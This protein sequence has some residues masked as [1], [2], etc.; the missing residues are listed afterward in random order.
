MNKE[1]DVV[2]IGYNRMPKGCDDNEM[3]WA[4]EAENKWATK[5]PYGELLRFSW[6]QMCIFISHYILITLKKP[7]SRIKYQLT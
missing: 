5:Y 1:N 7:Y 4:K 2:G 6:G 3:S